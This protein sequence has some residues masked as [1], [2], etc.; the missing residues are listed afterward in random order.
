SILSKE[1]EIVFGLLEK[2][3]LGEG[4]SYSD[5]IDAALGSGLS[6]TMIEDAVRE[7]MDEGRCYEPKIGVLKK[8]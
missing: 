5:V 8:V 2:L 3:D 4:A 7:L 1:E 6:E